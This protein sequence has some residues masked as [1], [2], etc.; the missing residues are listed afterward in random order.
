M[1]D[2]ELL[3]NLATVLGGIGSFLYFSYTFW[4]ARKA[5][6]EQDKPESS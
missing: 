5:D 4:A 3:A 1:F 6:K 2:L